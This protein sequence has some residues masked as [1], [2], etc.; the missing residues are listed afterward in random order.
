[1]A[2]TVSQTAIASISTTSGVAI[3]E[4][5][6][7]PSWPPPPSVIALGVGYLAPLVHLIGRGIYNKFAKLAGEPVL[8]DPVPVQQPP[9]Q[10]A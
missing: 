3:V 5:A 2:V 9:A 4:W 8:V 1:M 10:V 7:Q 6:C